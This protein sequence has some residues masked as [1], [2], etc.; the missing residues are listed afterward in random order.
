MSE[1]PAPSAPSSL[2]P[3]APRANWRLVFPSLVTLG[4]VSCA[5]VAVYWVAS[6]GWDGAAAI[7]RPERLAMAGWAV[8]LA[9]VFDTLDG[10]VARLLKAT[11]TFGL[12]LDSL[13]DF[14]SFGATPA[15]LVAAGG[16]GSPLALAA[17]LVMLFAA[18][19]RVARYNTEKA[20]AGPPPLEFKGL[21]T[22]PAG[23]AIAACM[24]LMDALRTGAPWL[25][26]FGAATRQAIAGGLQAGVPL[27][28]LAIAVL[29]VSDR[30]FPDLPKQ[31]LRRTRPRYQVVIFLVALVFFPV[32]VLTAFFFGYVISG[33]LRGRF[34]PAC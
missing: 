7:A 33:P 20:P 3:A 29:M 9:I 13:A 31:Y 30:R 8:M 22:P 28:A 10:Q 25:A 19:L 1:M 21:P 12:Q 27:L 5:A 17:A 15:L 4:S 32:P 11:S 18:V 14:I 24:L 16:R 26:P 2:E 6:M 23:G 34:D